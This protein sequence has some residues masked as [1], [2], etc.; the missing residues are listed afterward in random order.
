MQYNR[1]VNEWTLFILLYICKKV[2]LFSLNIYFYVMLYKLAKLCVFM[3]CKDNN[4]LQLLFFSKL[5][6][7]EVKSIMENKDTNL[8]H[9]NL[10]I[11]PDTSSDVYI[12]MK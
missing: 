3:S 1:G 9:D 6:C 12:Y 10:H 2:I 5:R 4:F 7:E 11:K 8:T